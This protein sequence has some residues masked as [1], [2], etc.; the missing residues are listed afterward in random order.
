[1]PGRSDT[2]LP[3][4]QDLKRLQGQISMIETEI[5]SLRTQLA[6]EQSNVTRFETETEGL[7]AQ[8]G[9]AR[10]TE[11]ARITTE[12]EDTRRKL[13]EA[14]TAANS[15]T[16]ILEDQAR[17]REALS[18]K[19]ANLEQ[20][21]ARSQESSIHL[22]AARRGL[23]ERQDGVPEDMQSPDLLEIQI[24]QAFARLDSLT[25]RYDSARANLEEARRTTT[26]CIALHETAIAGE[27]SAESRLRTADSEFRTR[28]KEA[29]F[30]NAADF[31][32]AKAAIPRLLEMENGIRRFDADILAAQARLGR[33]RELAAGLEPPNMKELED[34]LTDSRAKLSSLIG[35]QH[36]LSEIVSSSDRLLDQVKECRENIQTLEAAHR[37]YG[38]IAEVAC[39]DNPLRITFQRFVQGALFEDVLQAASARLR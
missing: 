21:R 10:D 11:A 4:E 17:D 34:L 13:V 18:R 23:A 14:R 12:L 37:V 31:L 7:I 32:T 39:G 35:D 24:E 36:R 38:R 16:A 6:T 20:A 33:A 15:L 26:R 8:L 2:Q 30:T 22:A 5:E 3:A 28:S 27:Q 9:N 25:K 29:G 1:M 19:S